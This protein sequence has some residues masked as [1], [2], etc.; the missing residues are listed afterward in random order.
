MATHNYVTWTWSSE[1]KVLRGRDQKGV[2][3]PSSPSTPDYTPYFKNLSGQ[4]KSAC[5]RVFK[6]TYMY[7]SIDG[8]KASPQVGRHMAKS[9][10]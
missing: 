1:T 2:W 6:N 3:M 10:A 8:A 9:L 5:L 7:Q 4:R